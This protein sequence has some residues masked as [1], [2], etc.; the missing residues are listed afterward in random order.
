MIPDLDVDRDSNSDLHRTL[1]VALFS[2]DHESVPPVLSEHAKQM[3]CVHSF[4][5]LIQRPQRQSLFA[6]GQSC[7]F[8]LSSLLQ[9]LGET[10]SPRNVKVC[11]LLPYL[12]LSHD[13]HPFLDLI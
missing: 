3:H 2:F 13:S 4:A 10:S 7:G 11:S 6:D 9:C 8:L 12:P 5:P 1:E